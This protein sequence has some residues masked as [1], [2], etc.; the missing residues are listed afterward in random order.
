MDRWNSTYRMIDRLV[1]QRR[2]VT[3]TLSDPEVTPRGK[4]YFDQKPEQWTVLEE[5]ARGLEPFECATVFLSGQEYATVPQLVKG[6]LKSVQN[7]TFEKTLG[8]AFQA[9]ISKQMTERWGN[10]TTFSEDKPNS[11]ILSATLDP[12]FR[13][14]KSMSPEQG[15]RV[16]ITVKVLAL[17]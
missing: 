15:I 13:E 10:V 5:L 8:K 6:L 11:V 3:A 12:R 14:P 7:R 4:R 9:A 16:Q 2:P 17:K 1:D